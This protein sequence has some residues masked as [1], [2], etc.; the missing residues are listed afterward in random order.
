MTDMNEPMNEPEPNTITLMSPK[1]QP[2]TRPKL[3]RSLHAQATEEKNTLIDK[4]DQTAKR[5]NLAERLVNGLKDEN[6]RWGAN[7]DALQAEKAMLVGNMMVA[8]PFIAYIGPFNSDFR[9]SLWEKTWVPD[10]RGREIPCSEELD[11]LMLLCDDA[12]V[13]NGAARA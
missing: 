13:W 2:P 1:S 5:L 7:V 6:E 9:T 3:A 10:L 11:P 12:Q 8:A 4:A